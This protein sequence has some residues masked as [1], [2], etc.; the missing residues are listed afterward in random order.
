MKKTI[1]WI[2]L[3]LVLVI[4]IGVIV[5]L[6]KLD[7][8]GKST[9]ES[10]TE[11]QLKLKTDLGSAHVSVF[12]GKVKLSDLKIGSPQGFTAPEMF[13]LGGVNVGVTYGQLR[14]DP[15]RIN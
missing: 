14:D 10:Q 9:V 1:K 12:G 8:I 3:A 6:L 4:V 5:V 15:I 7:G 11:N 13:A 2:V